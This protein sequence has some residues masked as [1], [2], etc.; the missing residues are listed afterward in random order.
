MAPADYRVVAPQGAVVRK[1]FHMTSP[2]VG[3]LRKG[4]VVTGLAEAW[5]SEESLGLAPEWLDETFGQKTVAIF[6][7]CDRY[8]NPQSFAEDRVRETQC[9][10]MAL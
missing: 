6:T 1:E 8:L 10:G 4:E 7:K 9:N 5:A 2:Q 3:Q